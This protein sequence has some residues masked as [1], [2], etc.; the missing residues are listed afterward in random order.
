MEPGSNMLLYKGSP[1]I[2]ILSRINPISHTDTYFFKVR[3]N[4][5]HPSTPRPSFIIPIKPQSPTI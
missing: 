3:S 1:I 4:I 2:Q 5:V